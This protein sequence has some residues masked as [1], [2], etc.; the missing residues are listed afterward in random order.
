VPVG[1][2]ATALLVINNLRDIP[3]DAAAGKNTLAVRIG[4]RPTRFLYVALLVLSF[5][6][7][8]LVAGLGE[9]PL[10]A[11]ALGALLLARRPVLAVLEGASG[12]DLVPVLGA[13]GRVQLV[14]GVLFAAGLYLSA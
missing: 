12:R 10:G 8:P 4:D 11:V 3:T 13:T 6:A 9:R 14:Y 2:L 1:F 5:V 7:V